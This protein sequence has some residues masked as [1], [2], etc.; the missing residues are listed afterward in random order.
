VKD[1]TS[2]KQRKGLTIQDKNGKCL[3]DDQ[4]ILNRWTEYCSD[5]YNYRTAGDPEVLNVPESK[6][7][8]SHP[9]LREEVETAVRSLKKGKSAGADNIPAELVQAGGE[10]MISALLRICN[11]S[12]RQENGQHHGR[13]R[14]SSPSPR[15]E[16]Y[17]NAIITAQSASYVTQARSCCR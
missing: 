1:L 4:D 14:S 8:D 10:A 9:I 16:I 5:L 17:N 11:K 3:T 13:S 7:T 12:G 6:D 15:K 2:T